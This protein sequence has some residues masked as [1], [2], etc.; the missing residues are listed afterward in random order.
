MRAK[1]LISFS[2]IFRDCLKFAIFAFML[3]LAPL[4]GFTD[5][6]FRSIFSKYFGGIDAFFIPYLSLKNGQYIQKQLKEI[7]PENN[8]PLRSVPQVLIAN[9]TELMHLYSLLKSLGYTEL[10]INMGCPYPMVAKR[11]RGSGLLPFPEKVL[12]ILGEC[13][14]KISMDVS[15]KIRSG[16]NDEAEIG[17][18]VEV[19]N[20]FRLSEIIYHPRI[21]S[22]LYKGEI[23]SRMF[24]KIRLES[25]NKLVFNGDIFSQADFRQRR[26]QFP[27]TDT[28]MLGR[29]ILMNPFLAEEINGQDT[30]I[31]EKFVRLQNFHNKLFEAYSEKLSGPGHVLTKMKQFWSYF[32]YSFRNQ[33][34]VF[35]LIKKSSGMEKYLSAVKKIFRDEW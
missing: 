21:A 35:K 7:L 18:M 20:Q 29:G 10:N 14:P 16:L 9:S 2:L 24:E 28:W 15:V 17:A 23:N 8:P 22:Q 6:I 12:S 34:K 1:L 11:G 5:Y 4:Q 3:Y 25:G 32:S 26:L 19:L 33:H 30:A 13:L 27:G 31:D